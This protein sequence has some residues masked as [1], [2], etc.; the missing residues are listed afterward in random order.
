MTKA[1]MQI[2]EMLQEG[3]IT[4]EE[5]DRLLDAVL[6]V[7]S[8][9][10]A[11][12]SGPRPFVD[13]P[14]GDPQF[15]KTAATG[16]KDIPGVLQGSDQLLRHMGTA[17]AGLEGIPGLHTTPEGGLAGAGLSGTDLRGA[18][19]AHR[20]LQGVDLHGAGSF[21]IPWIAVED[22]EIGRPPRLESAELGGCRRGER[23][24]LGVGLDGLRGRQSLVDPRVVDRARHARE[25]AERHAVRS[26]GERHTAFEHGPEAVQPPEPRPTET[27]LVESARAL[28]LID[29]VGL[30]RRR[31]AAGTTR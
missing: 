3:K 8:S 6:N 31:G 19:L 14:M 18:N 15:F 21:G 23:G 1:Q 16:F 25:R 13:A 27:P 4:A 9:Q 17:M 29:E 20:N 30:H 10:D 12:P 2:L 7:E 24:T 11:P 28:P 5:A 22:D 26:E